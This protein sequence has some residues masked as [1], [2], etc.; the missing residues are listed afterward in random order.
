MDVGILCKCVVSNY[1]A[2]VFNFAYRALQIKKTAL[3]H[4]ATEQH[5][6]Y[7]IYVSL[8][9]CKIWG[10]STLCP[11]PKNRFVGIY[12]IDGKNLWYE[13]YGWVAFSLREILG[14]II[15]Y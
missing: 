8:H 4:H 5:N 3:C 13:F 15:D 6:G 14:L 7:N 1:A 10:S 2:S 9:Y 11:I 12:G